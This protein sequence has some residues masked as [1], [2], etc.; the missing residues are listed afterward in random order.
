MKAILIYPH[1]LFEENILLEK[2][3]KKEDIIFL[4]EDELYFTQYNFHKI[5]IEFHKKT[6][7]FY[8]SFLEEKNFKVKIIFGKE[9]EPEIIK[10]KIN[11]IFYFNVVDDHLEKK[12]QKLIAKENIDF[13]TFDT[14]MFLCERADLGNYKATQNTHKKTFFMKNFYQWQ[15]LRLNILMDEKKKPVGG[16][17]SFDED[18]RQKIPKDIKIPQELKF[19]NNFIYATNFEDAKKCLQQ[20]L[21][22]K[23]NNFG[24][25]EDA[26]VDSEIFLFHSVLSPYLNVGLLTPKYVID[27]TIKFYEK[28]KKENILDG[29]LLQ[30]TEGFIRQIIGWREYMRFVYIELGSKSRTS[31]Y[32]DAQRKIPSSFWTGKTGI[33]PIDNSIK[34]IK[35]T[36]YDHHIPRLMIM[37]NFMNL[38]G[39]HPDE[40]HAWFM[41]NF[42]DAYDWVMVPNV[43]SMALYADGGL[44]T[45]K[46]YISGSAYVLKM[47]NFKKGKVEEEKSWDK[48]WDALFWSFVGKH[49]EKLSGEGRLGFIGVQYKKMTEEKKEQH[50]KMANEYL[51]RL[52]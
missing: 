17:W 31:N 1:Q 15:R 25:Y 11:K 27:E 43:Y 16:K 6:M 14:P 51:E 30:S 40:V 10:N 8:K 49:F 4:I 42:I 39:F 5:K 19:K 29:T 32:F 21:K 34:K 22:E 20:F 18:N 36:A 33:E 48:I 28:N 26:V 38:C 2:I 23:L 35:E 45:T 12:M 24:P 3:N 9:L 52:N 37:G 7:S 46:P 44:I 41:E 13:E 50:H 47:S